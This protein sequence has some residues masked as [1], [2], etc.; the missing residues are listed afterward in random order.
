MKY[1]FLHLKLVY[2]NNKSYIIISIV[3]LTLIIIIA[4]F[5]FLLGYYFNEVRSMQ[6]YNL[7]V[8]TV[9]K[10]DHDILEYYG[11]GASPKPLSHAYA[12][13]SMRLAQCMF[14]S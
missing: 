12:L 3:R 10:Q 13:V 6:K 2:L 8:D 1:S 11:H 4:I 14:G 9:S 7:C 5:V